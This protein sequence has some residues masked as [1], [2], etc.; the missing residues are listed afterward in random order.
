MMPLDAET[1]RWIIG[2]LLAIIFGLVAVIWRFIGL[3]IK[4]SR[5]FRHKIAPAKFAEIDLRFEQ[6]HH[7]IRNVE[8]QV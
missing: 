4:N 6:H 8:R 7:R 1:V 3:E 5:H 2:G